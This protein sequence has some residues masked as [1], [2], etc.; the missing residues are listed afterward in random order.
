MCGGEGE[1]AQHAPNLIRGLY[2]GPP[3]LVA[4]L[5]AIGAAGEL[6][7]PLWDSST[8]GVSQFGNGGGGIIS[9]IIYKTLM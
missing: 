6:I 4:F 7:P 1:L 5:G 3:G 9:I 2:V 8:I